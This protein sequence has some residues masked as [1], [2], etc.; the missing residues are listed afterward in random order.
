M[1]KA[2][3]ID[4]KGIV[5]TLRLPVLFGPRCWIGIQLIKLAAWVMPVTVVLEV[6]D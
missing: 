3:T 4:T 1:A 5:L 2:H 6:G